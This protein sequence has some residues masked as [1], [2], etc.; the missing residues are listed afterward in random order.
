MPSRD[1]LVQVPQ[2]PNAFVPAATLGEITDLGGWFCGTP[3]PAMV[4]RVYR[5]ALAAQGLSDSRVTPGVFRPSVRDLHHR[6]HRRLRLPAIH[7]DR[8]AVG[9]FETECCRAHLR[10]PGRELS[11][12]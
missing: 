11:G 6:L 9:R 4:V 10:T 7:E 2:V 8:Y 3:V 1:L 5:V 12:K